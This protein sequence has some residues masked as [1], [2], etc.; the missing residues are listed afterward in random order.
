MSN[1]DEKYDRLFSD[2]YRE[3]MSMF[4]YARAQAL[5][6]LIRR[7]LKLRN[8]NA[9]LDY[10][11]GSGIYVG[12]WREIFPKAKLSF[13]DI[14][15]VALKGL[16]AKFPEYESHC[17]PVKDGRAELGDAIFDVIVSVEVMEHVED[18]DAY[19]R[20]VHRLLKPGGIFVW[21]TPCANL[22][23][24]EHIYSL[25]TGNIQKTG[26]GYVRWRWED[27]THIRRMRTSQAKVKLKAAGFRDVG[28]RFRSHLFSFIC[29]HLLRGPLRKLGPSIMM[30]DYMLFRRL[31][32]AAAML[33]WGRRAGN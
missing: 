20:D 19:L 16:I 1:H 10:G 28:F 23:S 13:C 9:A 32:N 17:A 5:K 29:M 12:L 24:I 22:F 15:S 8:V 4:D 33:G 3:A 31:P 7:I 2:G 14:S 21:T 6:H 27:E 25:L 18:L 11:C 30:W 26:E